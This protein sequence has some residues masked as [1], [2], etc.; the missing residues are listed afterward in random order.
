MKIDEN[1]RIL[2][3][4]ESIKNFHSH[5]TDQKALLQ[6]LTDYGT[7]LILRAFNSSPK[8]L[9]DIIICFVLL[10]QIVAMLDSTEILLS[11][12]TSYTAHLPARAAFEASLYLEWMLLSDTEIKA[13]YYYV[14]N[15]RHERKWAKSAIAGTKENTRTLE[16]IAQ[17][18]EEA[19]DISDLEKTA[20]K[21]LSNVDRILSQD[22]FSIIDKEFDSLK[23]ANKSKEPQ[24]YAL[25]GAS[26]IR[27]IAKTL[28]RLPEY[29]FFYSKCSTIT[30]SGSYKDHII[31][32][33]DHIIAKQIRNL[34]K[35]SELINFSASAAIHSYR[36]VL[37]RYRPSELP[38]LSLTYR[39]QWQG[40]LMKIKPAIYKY[41][42]PV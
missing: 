10:K 18:N 23:K 4:K 37:A 35:I 19:F 41:E 31:F 21:H 28:Q 5:Y 42:G 36:I 34:E 32:K 16:T 7:N 14:S 30:H 17:L 27:G 24:W 11:N 9:E 8:S 20:E 22:A 39:D 29:D 38:S 6:S 13:K 15:I 3:R 1:K 2:D 40:P 26:S 33:K 12:G 25:A